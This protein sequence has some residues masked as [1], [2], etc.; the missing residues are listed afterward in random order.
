MKKEILG[1]MK[2]NYVYENDASSLLP[3]RVVLQLYRS[4]IY[5]ISE[6]SLIVDRS[7]QSSR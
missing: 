3:K 2:V 5:L 1:E 4:L 7:C 6:V